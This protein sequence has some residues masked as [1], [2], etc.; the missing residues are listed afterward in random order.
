MLPW[1]NSSVFSHLLSL[2]VC[3]LPLSLLPVSLH[4][5]PSSL[6]PPSLPLCFPGF[7]KH[8]LSISRAYLTDIT[9]AKERQAVF[10]MFSAC[11]GLGSIFGPLLSGYLADWDQ[12]LQ[13]SMFC[14]TGIFALNFFLVWFLVRPLHVQKSTASQDKDRGDL[15][16]MLSFGHLLSSLNIFK[17][18]SW[19]CMGDVIFV[20]F[21]MTF[22]VV[23]FRS[24]LTIFLQ[25]HFEVD[26][27]TLGWVIS[28]NGIAA[29]AASATCGH[30]SRLYSSHTRQLIHA[31]I[32][33]AVSILGATCAPNIVTVVIFLMP[34]SV[35]TSTIRI[36]SLS[37]MLSRV[38]EEEKGAVIGLSNSISSGSRMLSPGLV[39]VA[40]E[41][42]NEL[43]G[44]VSAGL[45]MTAA[46]AMVTYP[47]DQPRLTQP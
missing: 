35:A 9:E 2:Q 42:S 32:V 44:Y 29:V 13:L 37:L 16:D 8:G 40:Q 33:L 43:A 15:Q 22:A 23:M 28:F 27:K 6:P 3:L 10:G 20:R 25:E 7:L 5:Y 17:G 45:A 11:S 26:Y 12:T 14:G 19:R 39:G 38:S 4:P 46:I 21:L 1:P 47:L 34:M 24:N 41:F 18:I 36:C 30:I 31:V